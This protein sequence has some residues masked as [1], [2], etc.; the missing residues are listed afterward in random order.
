MPIRLSVTEGPHA[1]QA[2][3]FDGHDVFLTLLLGG[4]ALA[5]GLGFAWA[6]HALVERPAERRIRHG[7]RLADPDSAFGSP[8]PWRARISS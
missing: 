5:L 6:L 2:F 1:G 4:L 3:T 8:G 7:R